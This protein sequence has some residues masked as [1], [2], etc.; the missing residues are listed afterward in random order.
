MNLD[1]S[2][3]EIAFRNEVREFIRENYPKELEGIGSREDLTREEFLAWHKVLGKKGW[4]TPAWPEKYGG[5][6]W[7]STQRY[8]WSEENA[9]VD[10][11][12]P[13]PFGV[14]MVAPVIYTFGNEEQKARHLPGIRSGEVWWCQ[15]YS[16]PGAGSDL[17]SLK[18]TAVRDGDH[19]VLNGQKTWTTLAQHADWGF[20]LCRTDPTAKKPQEGISFILVDMNT[21]G[22]E[23][24]PIKLIDGTHEVNETWLTDVRVPVENLVGTE[25]E[26]W[27][28][29]KF[30]LAHERSG[31]AGV[32]RSKRGVERLRSIASEELV[33]GQPLLQ[34]QDFARKISQLEIDLTALEFTELRTLASEAAGKG[35]GP[36]SS[37]LKVKGT[38]IQQ[39]LTELT[40]EAV[41]N[42][43]AP[44]GYGMENTGNDG[45]GVGPD[46]ANFAAE[47]YFNMR[48]TS[49]YG[50]SNEIQRNIISKM[51]L[52]L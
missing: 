15:G 38:E 19:Y 35:P 36:E 34:S 25:N 37:I 46:H 27:T 4:S 11:L 26:G 16:E 41:G 14:S 29:A 8:I 47:T 7:T 32:A 17:A 24:K 48:K 2:P 22:I 31:I 52:G 3:E 6:G 10:A 42:Y 5:T 39:R 12:M 20:F 45:F 23:V 1:F 9:R 49:I 40:L 44:Y 51:I 13:L 28:Y 30:L 18:T 50:G 33:D 21:P 43:G